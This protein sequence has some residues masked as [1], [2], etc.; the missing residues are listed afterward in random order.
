MTSKSEC[1][2]HILITFP[3]QSVESL[4]SE[5]KIKLET[6]SNLLIRAAMI[7]KNYII[8][9]KKTL[10]LILKI[11]AKQIIYFGMSLFRLLQL[12]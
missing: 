7:E 5:I 3:N 6:V 11:T 1:T 9:L 12:P 10:V 2:K 8:S 4:L